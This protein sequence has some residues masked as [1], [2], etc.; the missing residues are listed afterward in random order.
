MMGLTPREARRRFD[1][2]IEFAELEEFTELKLKNYSSGMLVRLGFSLHDPGRRRR[3][4]DRRGARGRRR[5][6]PAE[7]ASTPSAAC[8]REGRTIVLVTH[9]MSTVERHCDRAILL[10]GGAIV[11]AGD[12]GDV[13]RR[14]LRAQLRAPPQ[15]R[16]SPRTSASPAAREV[17]RVRRRRRS[18]G[19][20]G[21]PV[22]SIEAGQPIRLEIDDRGADAG[23]SARS[24][25]SRSSTPTASRSSP[26]IRSGSTR[27]VEAR[28][29]RASASGCEAE[30]AN[31]LA[32]GHYYVQ[33]R[34]RPAAPRARR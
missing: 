4:A 26:P 20:D 29:S 19:A 13:A 2:V 15:P 18:L 7:V 8:T 9:D 23:S 5:V 17:A 11:E 21:A 14:Y 27:I 16:P 28:S 3:A 6:L 24:S 1:E 10:E 31:P 33:L 22:T 30:I 12:A 34:R 32:S 25:A